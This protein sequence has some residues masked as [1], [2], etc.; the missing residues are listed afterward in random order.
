MYLGLSVY[1]VLGVLLQWLLF[2]NYQLSVSPQYV[3]KSHGAWDKDQVIVETHKIQALKTS[4][5][6]WQKKHNIGSVSLYTAGGNFS[7]TTA[8]FTTINQLVNQWLY[9]V[10][11]STKNWM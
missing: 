5:F 10:E 9:Q 11:T 6:F 7:F 3:I 2:K 1:F 4:Q 8:N